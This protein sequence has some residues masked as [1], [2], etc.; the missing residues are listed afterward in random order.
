MDRVRFA[1]FAGF[2]GIAVLA[3][4]TAG[5]GRGQAGRLTAPAVVAGRSKATT[6]LRPAAPPASPVSAANDSAVVVGDIVAVGGAGGAVTVA[7]VEEDVSAGRLFSAPAGKEYYAVQVRGCSG[8]TEQGLAFSPRW[9]T[10]ELTD[11]SLHGADLGVKKPDLVEGKVP[12]GGCRDGWVTFVVPE[13]A[14]GASVIYDG[15][16][17]LEWAIP[18]P[19]G[20]RAATSGR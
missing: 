3:I 14:Q 5:C 15:S 20:G 8:P 19:H 11:G 18:P 1:G 9:F 16:R 10:L 17:R 4:A 12:A 7:A 13:R 6:P 2:A